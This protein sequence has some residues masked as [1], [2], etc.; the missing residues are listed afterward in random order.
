[1]LILGM[2]PNVSAG[3]ELVPALNATG[4]GEGGN[5]TKIMNCFWWLIHSTE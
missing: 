2:G 5:N 4:V 1:M 3:A